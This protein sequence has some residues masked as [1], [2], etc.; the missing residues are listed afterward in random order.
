[1]RCAVGLIPEALGGLDVSWGE[2]DT[3]F[4]GHSVKAECCLCTISFFFLNHM[5]I[6]S[7]IK[8]SMQRALW[9]K[10]TSN[11]PGKKATP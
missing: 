11:T 4:V 7:G 6:V 5:I 3:V 9:Y 8:S 10:K 2:E 1:M